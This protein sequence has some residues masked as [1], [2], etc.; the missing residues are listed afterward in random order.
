MSGGVT[1]QRSV[2]VIRRLCQWLE[3]CDSH[4]GDGRE[5]WGGVTVVHML[6]SCFGMITVIG[7][8]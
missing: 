8:V 6:R 3:R 2:K 5:G 4:G 1:V 7:E